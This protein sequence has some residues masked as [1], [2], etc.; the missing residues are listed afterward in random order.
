MP[1]KHD[2]VIG[3]DNSAYFFKVPKKYFW[4][5]VIACGIFW[6]PARDIVTAIAP[7]RGD[8][9]LKA[10]N[11]QNI[12]DNGEI[13]RGLE[14]GRQANS[15]NIYNL[16]LSVAALSES[17]KIFHQDVKESFRVISERLDRIVTTK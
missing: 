10:Y 8:K 12:L 3:A 13:I 6:N 16:N 15:N 14:A 4:Q 2:E 1:P 11:T 7:M 5:I 9:A 17:Q